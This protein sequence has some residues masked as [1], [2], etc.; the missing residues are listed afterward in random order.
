MVEELIPFFAEN[1]EVCLLVKTCVD[2]IIIEFKKISP[3]SY[4]IA[5]VNHAH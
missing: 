2:N 1:I 5:N 4:Q 3:M